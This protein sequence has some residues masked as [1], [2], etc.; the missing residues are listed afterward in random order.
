MNCCLT[1]RDI[2]LKI[3]PVSAY[4]PL[5]PEPCARRWGRDAMFNPGHELG[6]V[7]P[8]EI[9][10]TTFDPL[11]Y[12]EYFD[13]HYTRP[14][15]AKLVPADVNE[16]PWNRRVPG[17]VLY[18]HPGE[19]LYIHVLN[20]DRAECH[21]F[22]LHGL[23]YGIESD[24]AWPFGVASRSGRRSD[25]IRP[26][27]SWTY[28]FDATEETIGAWPFHDHV[29]NIQANVNLGLIG[30]LIVRD[31]AAPRPDHEIPLFV[32]QLQGAARSETF[33]SPTLGP[34]AT[35]TSTYAAAGTVAY[36][37]QIHGTSM[38]GTVVVD[39][40]APA[41]NRAVAIGDNFF[42]PAGVTVRPGASVKWTNNGSFDHI[43][44]APGGGATTFCL[45]G[46]AYVGNTPTIEARPGE[47]LRWYLCDL[48][49]G[50]V[51]HNIHPHSARWQLPTPSGGA[52][53]VHAL[54][55]AQTYVVDTEAPPALRVPCAL[56]ALQCDPPERGCRVPVKGE[57]LFHCHIEEHMMAGLAG[58]VRV[59]DWV[60]VSAEALAATDLLLPYD[61]GA[62]DLPWADLTRC[63][64]HC[65]KGKH[66]HPREPTDSPAAPGHE[67][68][69]GHEHG[70]EAAEHADEHVAGH[71]VM[72]MAPAPMAM[73]GM[74]HGA[75]AMA[76]MPGMPEALDICLAEEEGFWELLPCDS[77]V[78]AVHAVL[79]HTGRVLFFAGSGNNVPRFNARDVRSVVWDYQAGTFHIPVTPFDVFCAG[80]TVLPDGKVL[81]SGGTQQYDPFIGLRSSWFFDPTL[82][83]WIRLGD[84]EFGRWYPSLLT[85][86]DGRALAVSGISEAS[87]VFAPMAG[88][89][90]LPHATDLPLYPHLLLLADGTVFYTGGQLGQA[91][92]DARKIDPFTAAET[93]VPGLRSQDNRDEA[94]SVLL[95]PAQAQRVMVFGGGGPQHATN[96]TDIVD[97]TAGAPQ[98]VPGPDLAHARGLHNCVILPD[99]KVLVSGG[100]YRGE[101]RADAVHDAELYD[102]ATNTVAPAGTQLVSRL[103]HSIALLLPDGRVITAGS[104]PDR[105]DDELRLELYHPPYLFRG[106]R[107]FIQEA[108][109]EWQYGSTVAIHTPQ[110]ADI[111]WVHIIRP[112][113]VTHSDD[114]S[115]RLVDLPIR[116]RDACHLHVAV[117]E[118]PNLAPPGWYLLFLCNRAGIP[119]VAR[120]IHLDRKPAAP[121]VVMG[122]KVKRM[123]MKEQHGHKP[124]FPI[125]GFPPTHHE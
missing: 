14:N 69:A 100:G 56:E 46:R 84:M 115:Q 121:A 37:C 110:A 64:Q 76:A 23:R 105:G 2:F 65:P 125:P 35:Y 42:N 20:G 30:S 99:R 52:T 70:P 55:P 44:F 78:L 82:E 18:A 89:S 117:T 111:R 108:P 120:W 22:H 31:P 59:R 15:T 38:A 19:R 123:R 96:R 67:H 91:V 16:P 11:V 116:E 28:V 107:P 62:N 7:Q 36:H 81:V 51:W 68:P 21:S 25:E 74:A 63:G 33:K 92:L 106:P 71:E 83:E 112:M 57:F 77:K 114:T 80:Q 1:R 104:N 88:W 39:P 93:I 50:T 17:C 8:S 98:Y 119:S 75:A 29:R 109:Q 94:F 95:P 85:L 61:D 102:P 124:G 47:R 10:A 97:L 43:V 9:V 49:L 53:D 3:E 58:L 26:G 34:G 54:S 48:D 4:S 72:H 87:E 24:G 103:Y 86:G 118:N 32:H 90:T 5:A 12:H 45:N 73:A 122:E 41:G 101:T 113:A 66:S 6:R 79:I 27:E 40:A 60:W 13:T